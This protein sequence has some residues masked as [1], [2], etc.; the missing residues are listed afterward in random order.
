MND[1]NNN[2]KLITILKAE[3][4]ISKGT[5]NLCLNGTLERT[6]VFQRLK[7]SLIEK[8]KS[9]MDELKEVSIY[10]LCDRIEDEMGNVTY[11]LRVEVTSGEKYNGINKS[12]KGI[13]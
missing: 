5:F 4:T 9:E 8:V 7:E 13:K 1:I 6:A 12:Y 10:D 3:E 11:A 2:T